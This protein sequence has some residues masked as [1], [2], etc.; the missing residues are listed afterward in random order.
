M[1][2]G[3]TDIK[4]SGGSIAYAW[5]VWDHSYLERPPRPITD[6]VGRGN[7]TNGATKSAVVSVALP[8]V[9][10]AAAPK[11]DDHLQDRYKF[12]VEMPGR[13]RTLRRQEPMPSRNQ[14]W[15]YGTAVGGVRLFPSVVC[16]SIG[17]DWERDVVNIRRHAMRRRKRQNNVAYPARRAFACQLIEAR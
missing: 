1:P 2:P 10:N 16:S 17:A 4:A 9:S 7:G 6:W 14:G 12:C 11:S 15:R 3:G 13:T 5:F 8:I